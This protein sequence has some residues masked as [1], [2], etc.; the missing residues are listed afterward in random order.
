[1][2]VASLCR[3]DEYSTTVEAED[4]L[5]DV[6]IEGRGCRAVVAVVVV[7]VELRA[8]AV[9]RVRAAAKAAAAAAAASDADETTSSNNSG[10]HDNDTAIRSDSDLLDPV[11]LL[12][13]VLAVLIV[14][15]IVL[16]VEPSISIIVVDRSGRFSCRC[17]CRR[18][19]INRHSIMYNIS[20]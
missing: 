14:A 2:S 8:A 18:L 10:V 15:L 6:I 1:M 7:V 17:R 20:L 12:L 3:V 9:V 13:H 19:I 11:V 4:I 16:V 5:D